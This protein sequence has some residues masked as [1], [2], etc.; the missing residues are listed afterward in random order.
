MGVEIHVFCP[1]WELER[2]CQGLP[3]DRSGR[4][5]GQSTRWVSM[6]AVE[7][8]RKVGAKTGLGL[9]APGRGGLLLA[10]GMGLHQGV[11]RVAELA[12]ALAEREGKQAGSFVDG[13]LGDGLAQGEAEASEEQAVGVGRAG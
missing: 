4:R 8:R 10:G 7:E 3:G 11:G 1:Q 2:G 13:S 12:E 6:R 9:G 5:H